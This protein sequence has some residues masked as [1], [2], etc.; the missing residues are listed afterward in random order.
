MRRGEIYLAS[1]P[2]G[3][4]PGEQTMQ[5]GRELLL[6]MEAELGPIPASTSEPLPTKEATFVVGTLIDPERIHRIE[7]RR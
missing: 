2:F 7:E 3:D 6:Q 1:F 5:E 4:V